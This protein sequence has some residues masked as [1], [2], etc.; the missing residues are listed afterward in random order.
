MTIPAR[1]EAESGGELAGYQAGPLSSDL[2]A[3]AMPDTDYARPARLGLWVLAVGLGG[4]LS[5]AIF[6]PLDEAVPAPG[7]VSVESKRKRIDHLTGGLVEKILAREG[8]RVREGDELIVL[9]ETQSRAALN[10]TLSQW[11]VAAATEARL[12]A[13]R[14][15][16]KSIAFPDELLVAREE[17]EVASAIRAQEDLFHSRRAALE[18]E[19]RIMRESARGLEVQLRSLDQ[20]KIGREKQVELFNEQLASF[21]TLNKQ[22]FVSRNHLID[23]ERQLAEVQSKQS[24]DLAN[25]AG[26][27]A[28]LADFRM[29]GA[30]RET[31]FRREVEAQLAEVQKDVATQGE[32][33]SAVRD[34]HAR[35]AIRAPVSGTVVDIAIHTVGGVVKPGERIMDIVPDGDEL[36]VEAQ[37]PTQYIDR[38]HAGLP[39]NVHFDAYASRI[40]RPVVAGKVSVV[41]ADALSDAR[42]GAQF[43]S[44]RVTVPG[45]EL[46]KLGDLHLQP[47]MQGTVM[48]KTGERS[49]IVYLTRPLLR[50][51][52]TAL[53]E[54]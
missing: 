27:S 37:I 40:E 49:L 19:L 51:F 36:I 41:S 50:R 25:I 20:L 23:I 2:A 43:Y 26:V 16:R 5:W 4:F 29:R 39:A 30:Q 21:R 24:E 10:A 31:E 6:A 33:L 54:R 38:V 7:V 45:A 11:R 28:R 14:E 9:N 17:A 48:V 53:S 44:M 34:T 46:K 35:L 32:R 42:T 8:Q 1:Y 52:T 12:N 18:G 22:G 47:G 13:E 3:T 15:G